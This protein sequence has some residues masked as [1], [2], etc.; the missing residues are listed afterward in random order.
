M[1][2]QVIITLNCSFKKLNQEKDF[3]SFKLIEQ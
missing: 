3:E 2:G 1:P